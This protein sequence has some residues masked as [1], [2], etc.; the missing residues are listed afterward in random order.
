MRSGSRSATGDRNR[1]RLRDALVVVEIA[2]SCL[3]LVGPGCSGGASSRCSG[4]MSPAI[5]T[6]CSRGL[7]RGAEP[8]CELRSSAGTTIGRSSSASPRCPASR[9]ALSVLGAAP[10]LDRRHAL[11]DRRATRHQR[12]RRLQAMTPSSFATIG[13]S[14][15]RGR[16]LTDQDRHGSPPV[17]VVNQRFVAHFFPNRDPIG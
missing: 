7:V 10:G 3:L 4:S 5:P 17:I 14:I 8:V 15:V 13:L 11:Q 6:G 2:I 16:G 1:R 9:A 12:R